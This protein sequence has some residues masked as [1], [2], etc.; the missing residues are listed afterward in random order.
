MIILNNFLQVP[1]PCPPCP[2]K[3]GV[4]VSICQALS[5]SYSEVLWLYSK[6][7][8]TVSSHYH[9]KEAGAF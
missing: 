8:H 3:T 2:E 4:N 9:N 7:M 5:F 1:N 6:I